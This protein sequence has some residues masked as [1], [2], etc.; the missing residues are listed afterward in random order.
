MKA[1][2]FV[3]QVAGRKPKSFE[4]QNLY[5]TV[6]EMLVKE[7]C[8][9]PVTVVV[10]DAVEETEMA[11]YVVK[12]RS[13]TVCVIEERNTFP[14]KKEKLQEV[15]LTCVDPEKNAYK[16]YRLTPLGDE[17]KAS[18]GRMGT[19]KGQQFG[20][21]S[22]MYPA[23]MYWIKLAEKLQKGYQDNS[24]VYLSKDNPQESANHVAKETTKEVNAAS[25]DLFSLLAA[26]SKKAV[27]NAR[28]SVPITNAILNKTEELL[29]K[30]R[31][32]EDVDSFNVQLMDIISIL[33][34]PV[35]TG[36]KTIGVHELMAE[37]KSDFTRIVER[38]EDLLE[39]M[40]GVHYGYQTERTEKTFNDY[41]IDVFE[42]TE[43]Q[44]NMVL[45]HLNHQLRNSVSAVYRVIPKAQ[46][47]RFDAYCDKKN[48][49]NVKLLW[50]GSRNE[51]FLSITING[52]L[53]RPDA[54]ITGKAFGYG[55]YFASSSM[56]SV[57]Y[58]SKHGS[59]WA[60]G[61]SRQYIMGLYAVAYGKPYDV[62]T[63][64]SQLTTFTEKDINKRGCDSLHAHKG[65]MLH[66]DEI[67]V[68]NEAATCLQYLVVFDD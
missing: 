34:R 56:K 42:A 15:Y 31:K 23:H 5:K 32:A 3:Y 13:G 37:E 30:M 55:T 36:G 16:F 7:K 58:T 9:I 44:K 28:V 51:N 26:Y 22:F 46:K 43:D 20:E 52:L 33:Q 50:H 66:E 29:K 8:D 2:K 40:K 49:D 12:K 1:K 53:L 62:Y 68:Y 17:V 47:K 25:K 24:D 59:K 45:N 54:V 18:Y 38:E 48:I 27:E 4:T 19:E 39:A 57:G 21:R 41:N 10:R 60:N 61:R 63:H 6:G 35:R 11:Q 14:E 65:T 67:I 64:R